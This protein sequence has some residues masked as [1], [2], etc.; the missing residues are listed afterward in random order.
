MLPSPSEGITLKELPDISFSTPGVYSI[1]DVTGQDTILGLI[2][3][4]RKQSRVDQIISDRMKGKQL[5]TD[6]REIFKLLGN[7]TLNPF[8][9]TLYQG[10]ACLGLIVFLYVLIKFYRNNRNTFRK[11]FSIVNVMAHARR[12]KRKRQHSYISI[13]RNPP[14]QP[15]YA[16]TAI[17]TEPPPIAPRLRITSPHELN[18]MEIQPSNNP[19][20]PF[21]ELHEIKKI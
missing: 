10:F 9:Q 1:E 8:K 7:M 18:V 19:H 17:Q 16:T 3:Q 4:L 12:I 15:T 6:Q 20:Y 11:C 21:Q 13:P 14:P 2:K 5:T